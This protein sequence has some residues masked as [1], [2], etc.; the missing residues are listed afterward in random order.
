MSS[1]ELTKWYARERFKAEQ[2]K[3]RTQPQPLMRGLA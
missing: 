1:A 3:P 2:P